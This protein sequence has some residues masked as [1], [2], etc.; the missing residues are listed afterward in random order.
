MMQRLIS[1][2]IFFPTLLLGLMVLDVSAETTLPSRADRDLIDPSN[3]LGCHNDNNIQPIFSTPHAQ[4]GDPRTNFAT[5]ECETCHGP[6]GEDHPEI[7]FGALSK[8][9]VEEQNR[10][11]L[12]CHDRGDKV[13]WQNSSHQASDIACAAC[14]RIHAVRDPVVE[15]ST[16]I[17]VCFTC[18]TEQKAQSFL[19]SRHPF[20]EGK[21]VCSDCHNPHG[22]TSDFQ[23]KENTVTET[24]Y[25]CH[26]EK[27]G[28]FLWEHPPVQENCALCH[29]PHGSTQDRLL[30]VRTPFLC[31]QCHSDRFHPS[32]LYDGSGLPPVGAQSRLLAE[33]CLNCH[34]FVHGSNHPAG[35]AFTR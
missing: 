6:G 2:L 4:K 12:D 10:V 17:Q 25:A 15:K 22:S 14:H 20:R 8:T 27:R 16:Q 1:T 28:P 30:K 5:K 21:M 3:C 34:Y 19:R 9:P 29:N 32:T 7:A 35:A 26:T 31:Q 23:L 11:C 18:H 13:H 24:C 33:G